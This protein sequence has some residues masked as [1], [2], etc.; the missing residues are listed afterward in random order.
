MTSLVRL[1]SLCIDPLPARTGIAALEGVTDREREV[2]TLIARGLSNREIAAGMVISVRTAETHVQHIM[3]K[4]GF[5]ARSQ[6]AAWAAAG[7]PAGGTA[8]HTRH[9]GAVVWPEPT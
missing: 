3:V 7:D 5:T 2:L 9:R 4:L 8:R 6:I 1:A